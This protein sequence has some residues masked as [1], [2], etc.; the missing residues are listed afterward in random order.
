MAVALL[1]NVWATREQETVAQVCDD[2]SIN[3]G[4]AGTINGIAPDTDARVRVHRA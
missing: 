4:F 2:P 1:M 3:R